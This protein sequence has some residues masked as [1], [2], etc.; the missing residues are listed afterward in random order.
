MPARQHRASLRTH[1]PQPQRSGV[2]DRPRKLIPFVSTLLIA[3]GGT[4]A[5]APTSGTRSRT[6][7]PSADTTRHY[8][9]FHGTITS[10]SRGHWFQM[11]TTSNRSLRIHT[12]RQTR[13]D[14]CGWADMSH[15]HHVSVSAYRSHGTWY[16]SRMQNW[17]DWDHGHWDHGN[18][19]NGNW[20]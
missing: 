6:A 11:H 19:G 9:N 5:L 2:T 13:W 18:N 10:S 12:N 15:G 7:A 16:V 20:G 3:A 4:A 1:R 17:N 14:H 8:Y